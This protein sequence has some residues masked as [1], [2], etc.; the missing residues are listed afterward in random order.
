M[1][2][3]AN[4]LSLLKRKCMFKNFFK[5]HEQPLNWGLDSRLVVIQLKMAL[6][7]IP[8]RLMNSRNFDPYN[9]MPKSMG[10]RFKDSNGIIFL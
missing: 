4:Q 8:Q 10:N 6:P 2:Q 9:L 5:M 7:A 1:V 3:D